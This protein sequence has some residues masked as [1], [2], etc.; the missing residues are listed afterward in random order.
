VSVARPCMFLVASNVPVATSYLLLGDRGGAESP[1][2]IFC[3]KVYQGGAQSP[4]AS[5]LLERAFENP[6]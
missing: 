5:F 2:A 3:L 4:E 6:M 1:E